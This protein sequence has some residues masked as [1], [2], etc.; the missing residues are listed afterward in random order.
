MLEEAIAIYKQGLAAMEERNFGEAERLF[1]T[2][3]RLVPDDGPAIL[4]RDRCRHFLDS[5]PE[6][7]WDGA[8]LVATQ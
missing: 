1:N 3:L 2:A 7:N 6:P 5:P 8:T 4:M